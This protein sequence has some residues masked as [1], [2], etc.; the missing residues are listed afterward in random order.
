MNKKGV[1]V[2]SGFTRIQLEFCNVLINCPV[3]LLQFIQMLLC[4]LLFIVIAEDVFQLRNEEF[5]R[6]LLF[7][8][9]K[10]VSVIAVL[11]ISA[12]FNFLHLDT[13]PFISMSSLDIGQRDRYLLIMC[14]LSI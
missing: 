11:S 9:I 10:E 12:C 6:D 8:F 13:L 7:I 3:A 14:I 4:R 2:I 1:H 5:V